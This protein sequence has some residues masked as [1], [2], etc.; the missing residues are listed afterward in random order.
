MKLYWFTLIALGLFSHLPALADDTEIY[1]QRTTAASPNVVFIMDTS[2][3]MNGNVYEDGKYVGSRLDVVREAAVEVINSTSNINISLFRFNSSNS[4]GAW[5]SS[6]MLSIDAEGVR[7]MVKDILYSYAPGG[8][9][10]ITESIYEAAA[11]L[12]GDAMKYGK[13]TTANSDLCMV[14]EEQEVPVSS[15]SSQSASTRGLAQSNASA[16]AYG[17][18]DT[19]L[20]WFRMMANGDAWAVKNYYIK[21]KKNSL[22]WL[23]WNKARKNYSGKQKLD[24]YGVTKSEY[25]AS[26]PAWFMVM[27]AWMWSYVV[28]TST[29]LYTAWDDIPEWF[30]TNVLQYTYGIDKATYISYT[31]SSIVDDSGDDPGDDPDPETETVLVCTEYLNLDDTHDG[32]GNYVSPITE[33]CQTNH[34]VIFTDGE[35]NSDTDINSKVQSLLKELP[36]ADFPNDSDFSANCSGNGGCAEEISYYLYNADNSDA[37]EGRQ[38]IYVHTIGGFV[39]GSTQERL[40]DMASYG[41]GVSG[42]GSDSASLRLAL[43]KI[44]ENISKTS[45]TFAAPAVAVNAYNNLEHLD[46]LYYSVFS[47]STAA[48]WK[49]NIKRYR[50]DTS[51][52]IMD[53]DGDLAVDSTTG[54]FADNARS[55][56]TLDEDAPDGETVNKGGIARRLS[57]PA[58]RKIMTDISGSTISSAA[59]RITSSNTTLLS[60][61]PTTVPADDKADFIRWLAGYDP[62]SASTSAPRREMEDA[63]HSRPVLLSY[64]SGSTTKTALFVGTNSGYLHAFNT[65]EDNPKEYFAFIP[66]DLFDSAYAYFSKSAERSYGLDGYISKYHIDTNGNN[67]IDSGE[68]A[69]LYTGM[70]RGGRNY[71]AL[72]VSDL[73]APKLAWTIKGGSGDFAELGQTWSKMLPV[74]VLWKGKQTDVLM[75]AG[76]YDA[77]EDDNAKRTTHSMGNAIYMVEPATGKLLWKASSSSGNLKLSE[78]TSGIVGDLVPADNDGDGDVDTLYAADLG[79]R[80]WRLDLAQED[81]LSNSPATF[82]TGGLIADLGKDETEA[83]NVRFFSTPDLTYSSRDTFLDK[84]TGASYSA[85][86]Y[87][88]VIG[89]GYRAHPL[90]TATQDRIYIINDFNVDTAPETYTSVTL[91]DL[92]EYNKLAT[93]DTDKLKNGVYLDLSGSGE[94]VLS[95]AITLNYYSY[96][97]SYQ[98]SDSSYRS[99]CEPDTGKSTLYVLSLQYSAGAASL[100]KEAIESNFPGIQDTPVVVYQ[101][102]EVDGDGNSNGDN[103]TDDQTEYCQSI[104]DFDYLT[105]LVDSGV[106][107]ADLLDGPDG[108]DDTDLTDCSSNCDTTDGSGSDDSSGSGNDSDGGG[109]IISSPSIVNGTTTVEVTGG[110]DPVEQAYWRELEQ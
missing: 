94:K 67:I 30:R 19:N 46:Q 83:N 54:Y 68:K 62:S 56:W 105:H 10:P 82:A 110:D 101:E 96:I 75:F 29:G 90:N 104:T 108:T 76:G 88:L 31:A 35:P 98:P 33:E 95:N 79:G 52:D 14:W 47:P 20:W 106:C 6:P 8:G 72:D 41:G 34:V 100:Y 73:D 39:G 92:V 81:D 45:G 4:Q 37:F 78:M 49:G 16:K 50:L 42:N 11:Y 84:T 57:D 69:Y 63:L 59:N 51:G 7:N 61:L 55:Y 58:N 12:R 22:E 13:T 17:G 86:R 15:F 2:G 107:P 32:H 3:S 23:S 70:R 24:S 38:A 87:Q 80:I 102:K 85:G 21:S 99:G 93:A 65:D 26:E 25:E 53:A 97:N 28:N 89:S 109:S 36:S 74:T 71:Y 77:T 1:V 91:D 60:N 9:T 40:D 66:S 103:S 43:T 18:V 44:F 27:D 5:M 64:S 48:N